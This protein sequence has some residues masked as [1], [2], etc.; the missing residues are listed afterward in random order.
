MVCARNFGGRLIPD[1]KVLLD[2]AAHAHAQGK[3][4]E[5]KDLYRKILGLAPHQHDSQLML[6]VIA[7]QEGS[8]DLA[9]QWIDAAIKAKPDYLHAQYN[10]SVILRALGRN[11]DALHEVQNLLRHT[12]SFAAAWDLAGQILREKENFLD[13]EKCHKHALGL[14]PDNPVFLNNYGLLLMAQGK[15]SDAYA[16]ASRAEQLDPTAPPLLLGNILKALGYPEKALGCFIRARTILPEY[17]DS[18]VSEAI[19]CLQ[20]GDLEKGFALWEKRP[21]LSEHHKEV[22]LWQGQRVATLLLQEDQG[23]GDA[24]HFMRY[25]PL[26][27]TM[28]DQVILRLKPSLVDLCRFNFPDIEVCPEG[29]PAPNAS[30]RC[31]LSSLPFFFKTR[32]DNLPSIPYLKAPSSLFWKQWTKGIKAPKIGLVWAGNTKFRSNHTRSIPFEAL[33][34][35]LKICGTGHFVSIQKER[36]ECIQ[37]LNFA[38]AA[39]SLNSFQDTASLIAELDLIISVDTATAHLAGALGK[40]VFILLP[41]DPDWRW[42]IG[43]E[44]S[45]WYP[46]AK[47]YRQTNMDDWTSVILRVAEDVKKFLDGDRNVLHAAPSTGLPVRQNPNALPLK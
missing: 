38:D 45:P 28:V 5:A 25:V 30:A 36:S 34:P 32:F 20:M 16:L 29:T 19:A 33:S 1:T 41:F 7:Q 26:L 15:L 46:S 11:D 44:D 3:L 27:K 35:L 23:L 4:G 37:D 42:M 2:K 17:P 13:A 12:P 18:Y 43:R 31:R 9:L 10:R 47:L 14:H 40:P 6:G 39:P 22:P 21:D 8:S 24:L